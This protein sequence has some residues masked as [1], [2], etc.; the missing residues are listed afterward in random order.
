MKGKEGGGE[1]EGRK[2]R[3]GGDKEREGKEMEGKG[4]IGSDLKEVSD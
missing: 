1:G 3:R 4:R 2:W